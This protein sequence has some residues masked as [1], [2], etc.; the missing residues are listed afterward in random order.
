MVRGVF[1]L[2]PHINAKKNSLWYR[3]DSFLCECLCVRPSPPK[4]AV[5]FDSLGGCAPNIQV[6][7]SAA[8]MKTT[9]SS[10]ATFAI[11]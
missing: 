10:V 7:L 8:P 1:L 4:S 6:P 9:S 11:Y 2:P 3:G 5:T